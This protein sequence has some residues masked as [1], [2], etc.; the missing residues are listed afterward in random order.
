[1]DVIS[2]K[3]KVMVVVTSGRERG[4]MVGGGDALGLWC[5]GNVI[6]Y[7]LNWVAGTQVPIVLAMPSGCLKYCI[8]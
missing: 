3:F 7:F 8:I 6:W 4:N 1:M 2:I 5:V